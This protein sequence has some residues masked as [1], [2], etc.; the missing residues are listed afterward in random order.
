M[1]E[2]LF[3]SADSACLERIGVVSLI[4]FGSRATGHSTQTSDYDIG[5]LLEPEKKFTSEEKT[6]IYN[7]LYPLLEQQIKSLLNIDI[8]FL[9]D[10]PLEL[11]AHV[12]KYGIP[13]YEKSQKYFQDFKMYTMLKHADFLPHKREF[14]KNIFKSLTV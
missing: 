7:Q 6:D 9:Y 14:E 3:S 10:A 1:S 2:F 12:T 11:Q 13:V 8:V 4:L 5:V